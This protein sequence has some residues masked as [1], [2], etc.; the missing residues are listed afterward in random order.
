M[1]RRP[2]MSTLFPYTTL[3]RSERRGTRGGSHEAGLSVDV[4]HEDEE[5][6]LCDPAAVGRG[7]ASRLRRRAHWRRSEER[8]VG[9]ECGSG[10]GL[11]HGIEDVGSDP[12]TVADRW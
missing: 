7:E 2:P 6:R 5:E 10:G 1:I 12:G 8:R 4:R 9:K 3:F 11:G